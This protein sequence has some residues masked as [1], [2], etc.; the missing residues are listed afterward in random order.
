MVRR[1]SATGRD[2]P[3]V[4]DIT[5]YDR[6]TLRPRWTIRTDGGGGDDRFHGEYYGVGPCGPT[7]C[8]Y[9]PAWVVF[10][11][12][13]DG[14]ELWRT[15]HSVVSVEERN[16]LLAD[17]SATNGQDPLGG[18]S[19]RDVRTG[20]LRADLS[21]W[22]ALSGSWGRAGPVLGFTRANRTWLARVDLDRA[23]VTAIGA[24]PGW[25]GSC[26]SQ[27]DYVVCRRLDGSLRAWRVTG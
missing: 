8:L 6:T 9:G 2:A 13:G 25:Y 24:A 4:V 16:A 17:Q 15:R 22:R 23:S 20:A 21:G 27:R 7:L 1:R 3:A 19:V 18:L 12:P 10:L 5:A 26:D 14:R 11:D